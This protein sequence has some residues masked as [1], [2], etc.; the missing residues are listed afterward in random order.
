MFLQEFV[1]G[2]RNLSAGQ[3]QQ[4]L[5]EGLVCQA[6]RQVNPPP[7]WRLETELTDANLDR[8]R[9]DH[10]TYGAQSPYISTTA[11]TVREFVQT[12]RRGGV[13]GYTQT[14]FAFDTAL[15]FAVLCA[16]SDGW[17]FYGYHFMLGRPAGRHAE[18]AE[19]VRDLHQHP[20][21][22]RYR[23]EGE[24]AAAIRIPPRRIQR[25]ELYRYDEVMEAFA[26][27]EPIAPRDDDVLLN[28]AYQPPEQLLAPR[29]VI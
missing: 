29:G 3:V 17:L 11:G 6:L 15:A 22:S 21:W 25:A 26:N 8:H 14:L 20:Q 10:V 5:D 28:P 13:T 1:R 18:F 2:M 23:G 16:R 27:E 9:H 7:P 19:E 4:I 12:H 24:I